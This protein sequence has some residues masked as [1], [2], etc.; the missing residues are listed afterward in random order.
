M[1]TTLKQSN[2]VETKPSIT[3][4]LSLYVNG[5]NLPANAHYTFIKEDVLMLPVGSICMVLGYQVEYNHQDNYTKIYKTSYFESDAIIIRYSYINNGDI[6][7]FYYSKGAEYFA[8]EV[9]P[10]V[11]NDELFVPAE[12]FQKVLGCTVSVSNNGNITVD[13]SN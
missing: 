1:D 2:L 4:N 8:I 5:Q 7:F 3:K 9:P 6:S 12:F 11:K 13:S 10:E